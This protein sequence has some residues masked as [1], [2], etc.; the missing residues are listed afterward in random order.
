MVTLTANADNAIPITFNRAAGEYLGVYVA[1]PNILNYTGNTA[2]D[3][4]WL[5]GATTSVVDTTTTTSQ[6]FEVGFDTSE[7]VATATAFKAEQAKT[8]ALQTSVSVLAASSS[9][10]ASASGSIANQGSNP[11]TTVFIAIPK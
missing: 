2:D 11:R 7:P 9:A 6:R 10:I 1:G 5:Y 8:T 4:G 3:L